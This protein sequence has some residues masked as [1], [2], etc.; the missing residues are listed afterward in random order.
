MPVVAVTAIVAFVVLKWRA[1]TPSSL[2]RRHGRAAAYADKV[3]A[4]AAVVHCGRRRRRTIAAAV[5]AVEATGGLSLSPS[6]QYPPRRR[7][8]NRHLSLQPP[9]P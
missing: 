1:Q 5:I 4:A 3:T 2:Y 6:P 7:R 9:L 8:R